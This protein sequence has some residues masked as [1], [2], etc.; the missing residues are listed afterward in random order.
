MKRQKTSW[1]LC[2][3]LLTSVIL[4]RNPIESFGQVSVESGPQVKDA[5]L[6]SSDD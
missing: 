3:T 1:L 6:L 4:S 2:G 5:V